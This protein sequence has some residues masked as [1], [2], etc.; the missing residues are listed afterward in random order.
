MLNSLESIIGS[1]LAVRP[2]NQEQ[3]RF[4]FLQHSSLAELQWSKLTGNMLHSYIEFV[5]KPVWNGLL[6]QLGFI[7]MVLFHNFIHTNN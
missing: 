7:N 1:V 4:L 5:I 6:S 3:I 2:G